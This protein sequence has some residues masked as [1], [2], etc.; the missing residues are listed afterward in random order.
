[1][2]LNSIGQWLGYGITTNTSRDRAA[3]EGR[4]LV[5]LNPATLVTPTVQ[6]TSTNL[7]HDQEVAGQ[8]EN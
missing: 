7:A 5:R 3:M 4:E 1:M 2:K 6:K 8:I